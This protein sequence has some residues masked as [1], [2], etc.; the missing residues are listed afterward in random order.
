M[1]DVG[2]ELIVEKI[3]LCGYVAGDRVKSKFIK[4]ES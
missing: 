1:G 3:E 4:F 2:G